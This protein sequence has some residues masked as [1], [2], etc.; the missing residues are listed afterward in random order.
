M[1]LKTLFT[2]AILAGAPVFAYA[3]GC[4]GQKTAMSCADG[5]TYDHA[6]GACVTVTG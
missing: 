4:T 6:S 3:G 5:M 1:S 2:A